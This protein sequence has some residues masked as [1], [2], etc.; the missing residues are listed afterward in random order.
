MKVRR[1]RDWFTLRALRWFEP[2]KVTLSLFVPP[3]VVQE[4]GT[5]QVRRVPSSAG[6][7]NRPLNPRACR[8]AE[9]PVI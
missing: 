7:A 8:S 5:E 1:S 2:C 3:L 4:G 6:P 9:G